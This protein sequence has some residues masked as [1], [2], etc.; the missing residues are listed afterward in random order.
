LQIV[1]E[2]SKI[3]VN[4]AAK[5]DILSIQRL[6][7]ELQGLIGGPQYS[8]MF[9]RRDADGQFSSRQAICGAIV[10]WADPDQDA[11]GCDPHSDQLQV[12]GP[13][14]SF[15]Q[16]LDDP[17]PRKNA[18]FDSL[19]ELRMVRGVGDDFWA[20]FVQPDPYDH[21]SRVL[22]VWGQDAMNVNTANAQSL[23]AYV[24]GAAVDDTPICVDPEK[25]LTFISAIGL[26]RGFVPGIPLFGSP[27]V[28]LNSMK[29]GGM[30]GPVLQGMDIPPVVFRSDA[31]AQKGISTTSKVFS[32]V[33]TGFVK[34]FK[35]QTRVRIHAVVDFRKAP[36]PWDI[37]KAYDQQ[38]ATGLIAPDRVLPPGTVNTGE[39]D[40]PNR[41]GA[42]LQPNPDGRV[43]YYRVN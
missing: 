7:I 26:L 17:Y 12:E 38:Q 8:P 18:A 2:D 34:A 30:L 14:D 25:A 5:G 40:E 23:H 3:N 19:E 21:K 35:R 13:E 9:E 22:T 10:D 39:E 36:A 28:F 4:R 29:G 24:C 27:Q 41:I 6:A 33:V 16:L 15:Y 31:E 37:K 32:I 20:T 42:V 43:I 1:D 11:Y